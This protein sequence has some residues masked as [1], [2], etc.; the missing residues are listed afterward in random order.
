MSATLFALII[1]I[2][3]VVLFPLIGILAS[4]L[5]AY[6]R[7]KIKNSLVLKYVDMLDDTVQACVN[8]TNQTYVTSLKACGEFDKEA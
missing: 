3:E 6:I 5:I 2:L 1:K 8:A 4:Y 7:T